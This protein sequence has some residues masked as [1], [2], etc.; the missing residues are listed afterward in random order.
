[1]LA[2][3]MKVIGGHNMTFRAALWALVSGIGFMLA[4]CA[5]PAVLVEPTYFIGERYSEQSCGQ[6]GQE[7]ARLTQALATVSKHQGNFRQERALE[8]GVEL[9]IGL[10]ILVVGTLFGGGDLDAVISDINLDAFE[11]YDDLAPEIARLKGEIKAV[12]RTMALKICRAA[13][14]SAPALR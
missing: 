7:K 1:M 10:P 9:G 12:S 8:L 4:A 6:L 13:P 14:P 5:T 11:Y 2:H 3:I